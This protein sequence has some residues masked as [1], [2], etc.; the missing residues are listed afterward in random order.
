M[1]PV[2]TLILYSALILIASL[3]GG[4]IPMLV[5]LTHTRLQVATSFVSGLMLGV[6]VLHLM[7]HAW[8]ELK[9]IDRTAT[10]MLWG[11]LVMFFIQRFLHFHHHDVPEGDPESDTE[12]CTHDH[13]HSHG[14]AHSHNQIGRAHV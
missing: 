11:F 7:P 9:S 3:S 13:D 4:W 10:W 14:P 2:A 5:R 8:N 6:G 1:T 12:C